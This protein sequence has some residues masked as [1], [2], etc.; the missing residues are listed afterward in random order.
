MPKNTSRQTLS[1]EAIELIAARFHALG[2]VSRLKLIV[3][4]GNGEKNVSQLVEATG[5]SQANVSRHLQT[6][7]DA[8]ILVRRKEGVCVFYSTVDPTV[9]NLCEVVGTSL[10]KRLS[11]QA[12][13]FNK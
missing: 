7:T 4:V 8:G 10:Q 6:L 12:K 1:S 13:V 3:A 2:E 9:F 11:G 5:L